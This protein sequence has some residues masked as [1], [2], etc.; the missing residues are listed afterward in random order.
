MGRGGDKDRER[1]RKRKREKKRERERERETKGKVVLNIIPRSASLLPDSTEEPPLLEDCLWCTY[2]PGPPARWPITAFYSRHFANKG[3]QWR[4]GRRRR[5]EEGEVGGDEG[6]GR[7]FSPPSLR[8]PV[9]LTSGKYRE[10]G[11]GRCGRGLEEGQGG[12]RGREEALHPI[13]FL[14]AA[15]VHCLL[16]CI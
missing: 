12:G 10:E 9:K 6:E 14:E 4:L 15:N 8:S 16:Y 3:G 5:K 11:E 13:S 2:V 1:E 7:H